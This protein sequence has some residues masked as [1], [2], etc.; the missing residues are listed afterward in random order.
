MDFENTNIS[1]ISD[2]FDH[3]LGPGTFCRDLA[4]R[5]FRV[6]GVLDGNIELVSPER[7]HCAGV[8]NLGAEVRELC[9]FLIRE[10][11]YELRFGHE[12]GVGAHETIYIL[13]Y[14][15]GLGFHCHSHYCG[16]IVA[17]AAAKGSDVA[18][19]TYPEETRDKDNHP[20]I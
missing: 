11:R 9:S 15:Q 2:A 18:F 14:L 5:S 12:F 17:A 3:L 7:L 13:P 16:R 8:K 20:F 6:Q 10:N 19:L 1:V 4:P